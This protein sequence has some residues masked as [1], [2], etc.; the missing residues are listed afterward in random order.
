MADTGTEEKDTEPVSNKQRIKQS[1][2]TKANIPT[3]PKFQSAISSSTS[4]LLTA[5]YNPTHNPKKDELVQSASIRILEVENLLDKLD[6]HIDKHQRK[7]SKKLQDFE[8]IHSEL[9]K[10][11]SSLISDQEQTHQSNQRIQ[12]QIDPF[13]IIASTDADDDKYNDEKDDEKHGNTQPN[14]HHS[15]LSQLEPFQSLVS[16]IQ[17]EINPNQPTSSDSDMDQKQ[18]KQAPRR[19]SIKVTTSELH[20]IHDYVNQHRTKMKEKTYQYE[21][22]KKQLLNAKERLNKAKARFRKRLNKSKNRNKTRHRTHSEHTKVR[23]VRYHKHTHP[24]SA[25][26]VPLS[27]TPTHLGSPT[28]RIINENSDDDHPKLSLANL[29]KLD[30]S[31]NRQKHSKYLYNRSV[32]PRTGARVVPGPS[33]FAHNKSTTNSSV[34][35]AFSIISDQ[36]FV[37]DFHSIT[38]EL[39]SIDDIVR[40]QVKSPSMTSIFSDLASPKE[41]NGQATPSTNKFGYTEQHI[42]NNT[43]SMSGDSESNPKRYQSYGSSPENSLQSELCQLQDIESQIGSL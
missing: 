25:T 36:S 20:T 16:K 8:Q 19:S 5:E 13:I 17:K 33:S 26:N 15:T 1:T 24:H 37:E 28:V 30:S 22:K 7:S 41:S 29:S 34:Q 32:S 6:H 18:Q 3:Q 2:S 14:V 21:E 4:N 35:S 10:I 43:S 40:T 11:Q 27:K 9:S 42:K 12:S 31:E 39:E 23:N 38:A